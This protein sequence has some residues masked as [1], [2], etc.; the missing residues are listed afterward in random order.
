LDIKSKALEVNIADYH[1]DVEIDPRYGV[2][3]E[4]MSKYFGL[5]EG[6]NT[7]LKELTHPY[8]NWSFIVQEARS[9]A[10]DYFHLLE[11][12]P[13]GPEAALLF[14]E[15]F[16]D[17]VMSND[18]PDVKTEAVDNLLLFLQKVISDSGPRLN[19]FMPA[20]SE[21]FDRIRGFGDDDFSLIV[22]SYYQMS[23]LAE[24]IHRARSDEAI[25]FAALNRLLLKY[26]HHGYAY[27][28]Q[29]GDP[30]T[31]FEKE[32]G[33]IAPEREVAELFESISLRTVQ[34]YCDGVAVIGQS[35]DLDARETLKTLCGFPGY[36]F[37]VERYRQI[38]R[39]LM[40]LS[41]DDD[42]GN[43]WKIIFLFHMMNISGLSMVHKETLRDI[44][45]TLGW[46]IGHE[47]P[48]HVREL[49]GK[50]FSI[51]KKRA[52]QFPRTALNCVLNMGRGVYKTDDI[53]LINY[54][55]DGV[56]D[57][58]FQT[59]MVSGV[60]NDWQIKVNTVHIENVRTW[61]KIIELNPKWSSRLLSA[62][63]IHLSLSGI[64]IKDTDLFPRD[65]TRFLNSG[66]EPVYNLAKQLT[67]LF[68]AFFNDIGAE[69]KLR[70]ISTRIDELTHRR[71]VLIH[72]LRKQSHV[73]SSNL[74][75]GFMEATLYFWESRDKARL[76]PYVPPDIFMQ[77]DTGGPHIDGVHRVM[78]QIVRSGVR[79]PD[80]C[81]TIREEDLTSVLDDVP[82]VTPVDRERVKLAIGFY[83]L[84]HQ[85]YRL[86]L[87]EIEPF[88]AQLQAEAFPDLAD[89]R[90]ALAEQDLEKKLSG[91]L[92]YLL[93]LKEL[94]LSPQEYEVREDI[95]Q[96][97][98]F[99]VDI[100]SMYG[101]YYELKFDALGLTYR[102][103][104]LVNVLFEQIVE[105][106]DLSLV[107]KPRFYE[108][109]ER[110]LL[111]N[112]ALK[113]DGILSAEFESHL[114][115]LSQ[116]LEVRGFTFTQYRDIFKGLAQ[117]VKNVSND[118]INNIHELNLS[119]TVQRI[120]VD[121]LLPKY[122]PQEGKADPERLDIRISEIFFR[123]RIAVSLGLQQLDLYLM[124]ILDTI[125]RQSERLH[126]DRLHQ[127]LL[128]D[129]NSTMTTV[130]HTDDRLAG[131]IY[132]GNKGLN[133]VKLNRLGLPV[134]SGFIITA[135]V[136]RYRDMIFSYRPAEQDFREQVARQVSAL[137]RITGKILGAPGN[138]LLLSVRS[139]SPISHPGMMD[140]FLNVGINERIAAGLAEK[141]ENPW[142]AWDSYRRF[143][144]TYGMAQGL[145]RDSFDAIINSHKNRFGKRYKGEFSGQQ[146]KEVA[147]T[148]KTYINDSGFVIADEPMEQLHSAIELV[149]ASWESPKAKTYRDIMDI[150]D[151]WGTAVTIQAMV[152]GN[153]SR[154]SGTGVLFTHNP[155]WSGD[156]LSLWGDFIMGNQGED[157]VSGLVDSLPITLFQQEREKR[158]TDHILETDFPEIFTA[159]REVTNELVYNQGYGPQEIEFTFESPS[160]RDLYLLQTRDMAMRER[161]KVLTFEPGA[162]SDANLLGHGIGLSGG[163]MS[164][165]VVFS[166]EEIGKWR[167]LEPE[168]S[169]ILV[170]PDTVPDDIEEIN[171]ADGLLTARGGVT[172]HA[173]VVA[174]RLEKT[175]VVGCWNL[176][177]NERDRI[178]LFNDVQVQ[179]GE[180]I[181]IDGQSGSVHQGL[182]KVR[183]ESG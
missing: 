177:C 13:R 171:A 9:Y 180:H 130:D 178:C 107:T 70:D 110:L 136:Y 71:D 159:L 59:P 48:R 109:Y 183:E 83:R 90:N 76:E 139:G 145:E 44:N 155:R 42:Q 125:Y 173:A 99:T 153:I 33:G 10:L 128:Y 105:G 117:A 5:R 45:R 79:I 138:P 18:D 121:Q 29:E 95:Y 61:L 108:I 27:W 158:E 32:S 92:D 28:I 101:S 41:A 161:K 174:H 150:S 23:K 50:T 162:A 146:M 132:L 31:W 1:V 134:P 118:H 87:I 116:S 122:R 142:Y 91:L 172:S 15:I 133:L 175:C 30:L 113:I 111:F 3:L 73:E 65:I 131:V 47:N 96:K 103:E 34:E 14:V 11:T 6:L 148:Y 24:G 25:G 135:E 20:L 112:K 77:I 36:S 164:G 38:P 37:F 94:I 68:P 156:T 49:L 12:H 62:M 129:P 147:L 137:Q 56:I 66:I 51:I 176:V 72:Y 52:G 119:K 114:E 7:F 179:S 58:G 26:L 97:R 154:Q 54:F 81:L 167:S 168:T 126:K 46:L 63:I 19:G 82:D 8:R 104:S 43:R 163:A 143:L 120:P 115:F 166:L 55:I 149:L 93:R 88:L 100:P 124:R 89:L 84:L 64:F 74:I 69:G 157:V 106:I 85:K 67:R 80:G 141:T 98:H 86:N 53:D 22:K 160:P 182:I 181:S 102:I 21:T 16:I 40:Q 169:L 152:F 2:L 60:G 165:R 144:Q 123:D 170:R 4:V 57:L 35:S 140:T 78:A 127:L 17:A 151:D 75:I 39:S